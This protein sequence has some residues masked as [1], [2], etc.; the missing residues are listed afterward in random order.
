MAVFSHWKIIGFFLLKDYTFQ[1]STEKV[2]GNAESIF[3]S[4]YLEFPVVLEIQAL[5]KSSYKSKWG[6]HPSQLFALSGKERIAMPCSKTSLGNLYK[7]RA[8]ITQ[9]LKAGM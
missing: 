3:F 6:G 9:T 8:G 7:P 4:L 2:K 5:I 1:N